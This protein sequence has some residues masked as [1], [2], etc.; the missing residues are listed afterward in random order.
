MFFLNLLSKISGRNYFYML[1]KYV[2]NTHWFIIN[3]IFF[4]MSSFLNRQ[5]LKLLIESYHRK[6]VPRLLL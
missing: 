2:I 6:M 5:S 3:L 4:V 1:L